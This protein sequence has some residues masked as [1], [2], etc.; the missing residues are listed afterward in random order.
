V[1]TGQENQIDSAERGAAACRLRVHSV[2]GAE[3]PAPV[4]LE[5]GQNGPGCHLAESV[6]HGYGKGFL[7]TDEINS[8]TTDSSGSRA[9]AAATEI[10][11]FAFE[12]T[13][14]LTLQSDS[15]PW[16]IAAGAAGF[17]GL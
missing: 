8:A 4:L 14:F 7:M 11:P 9:S 1:I 17:N 16:L 12:G 5:G 10:V 2:C 3:T 6:R 13:A 15:E